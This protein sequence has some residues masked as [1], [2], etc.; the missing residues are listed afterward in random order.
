LVIYGVS[1]L[2]ACMIFGLFL[3]EV[4]GQLIGVQANVGGVGIAM[5]LMILLSDRLRRAGKLNPLTEQGILFWS[6]IY[7]PVVVAMAAKQNVLAAVE[8]GPAAIL[9]GAGAVVVSFALV[10]VLSSVG[11]TSPAEAHSDL[12]SP[13]DP[14]LDQD[15]TSNP[16]MRE[17]TKEGGEP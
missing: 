15:E 14:H 11:D 13:H 16:A 8:G 5:L 10:P 2:A 1:I 17:Q 12:S 3:G 6:A 7:I 4:L 9:A